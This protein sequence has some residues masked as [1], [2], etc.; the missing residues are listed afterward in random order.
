M[1]LDLTPPQLRVFR[2]IEERLGNGEP[3]PTYREICKR[4][5]YRSTKAAVDHV[6]ALV[7]K[8]RIIRCSR[9]ARGLQLVRSE[10]GIPLLGRIA[11]GSPR[12]AISECE[13][14]LSIDPALFGISQRANA[15]AVRVTGDSMNGRRIVEGDI[16]LLEHGAVP[17]NGDVVAALIDNESTL[18]TFVRKERKAWLRAENPLYPDLLPVLD[19]R[20]Q[21]VARA[22]IR[23]LNK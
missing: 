9:R 19:L 2:F 10:K 18:K 6:A 20:I 4:F 1:S 16:V 8:G 23:I 15:F 22:V 17:E 3:S 13:Q 5:G 14:Y 21:G 7:K 12:E 11:A